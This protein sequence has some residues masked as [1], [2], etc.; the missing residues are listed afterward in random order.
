[1]KVRLLLLNFYPIENFTSLHYFLQDNSRIKE[2]NIA[3]VSSS[4]IC[5]EFY[6]RKLLLMLKNY[7]IVKTMHATTA[8]NVQSNFLNILNLYMC[9][10]ERTNVNVQIVVLNEYEILR[11]L[12]D[13]K[14]SHR[15]NPIR[16]KDEAWHWNHKKQLHEIWSPKRNQRRNKARKKEKGCSCI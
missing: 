9:G 16:K 5:R 13:R 3:T 1:M 4:F 2:H 11:K 8:S 15:R 6:R 10:L 12:K 7:V 14:G